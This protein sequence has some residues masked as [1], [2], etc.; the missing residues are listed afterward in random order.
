MI[1]S[2]HNCEAQHSPKTYVPSWTAVPGLTCI[3]PRASGPS[4]EALMPVS[5]GDLATG[6]HSCEG[7]CDASS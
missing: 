1:S 6:V 7:P 3:A 2:Q 4:G 5:K